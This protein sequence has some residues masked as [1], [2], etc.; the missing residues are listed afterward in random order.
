MMKKRIILLEARVKELKKVIN[1]IG[2]ICSEEWGDGE[3][4]Y[5]EELNHLFD[6]KTLKKFDYK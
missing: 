1:R 3:T 5:E 4:V 2:T 6:K